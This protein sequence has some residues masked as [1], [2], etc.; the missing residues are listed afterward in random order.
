MRESISQYIHL[1]QYLTNQNTS[2]RMNQKIVESVLSEAQSFDAYCVLRDANRE[3]KGSVIRQLG[4]RVKLRVPEGIELVCVPTGNCQKYD[5]FAF[6]TADLH[7]HNLRAIIS[8]D[9][10]DYGN[11]YFGFEAEDASL[12]SDVHPESWKMLASLFREHFKKGRSNN[13]WAAW[14]YWTERQHWNDDVISLM[15]FGQPAFDDQ[16]HEL[17]IDLLA[18][19][20]AFS[21][22]IT[23]N[24]DPV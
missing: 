22:E 13:R 3:I 23:V 24:M 11:C 8:F 14:E 9:S 16:L 17:I 15:H 18:V 21:K 12:V 5:G 19:A 20:K 4:E 7:K 1:I 6:S 2:T 10:A